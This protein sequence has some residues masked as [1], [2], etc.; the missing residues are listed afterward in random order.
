[1]IG[2]V[3]GKT[4]IIFIYE[5]ILFYLTFFVLDDAIFYCL[6][7]LNFDYFYL[8]EDGLDSTARFFFPLTMLKNYL[9]CSLHLRNLLTL[10]QRFTTLL[11]M[12][13]GR[14]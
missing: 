12:I 11:V 10:Q 4:L 8:T 5:F 13:L 7:L 3:I 6:L 1:M 2:E 14:Y 9:H